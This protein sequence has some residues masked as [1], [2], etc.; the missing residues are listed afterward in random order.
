MHRRRP[1]PPTVTTGAVSTPPPP[2][3]PPLPAAAR[4]LFAVLRSAP[5]EQLR[6]DFAGADDR[7]WRSLTELALRTHTATQVHQRLR[8]AGVVPPPPVRERLA[9]VYAWNATR[10]A[11]L[12]AERDHAC[13]VVAGAG[14][15]VMVLKS[16]HLAPLLYD[17]VG[18]RSMSDVDLLVARADA[19]R[20]Q[21]ALLADGYGPRERPPIEET[22]R[23]HRHLPV[24]RRP[25]RL[26]V[27]LHWTLSEGRGV[28]SGPEHQGVWERAVPIAGLPA[29]GMEP[30]DALL[31]TCRHLAVHHGFGTTNGLSGL[32]DA[33]R[34]LE[35]A[36]ELGLD[37]AAI[38]A[39]A[40]EWRIENGVW[41]CLRLAR[42]LLG[43]PVDERI[44]AALQPAGAD[45][46]LL[47]TAVA[48][49]LQPN[50]LR[51][52]VLTTSP[53]L[54]PPPS[55][56]GILGAAR[57]RGL[58]GYL[59]ATAF[60]PR[61]DLRLDR[62]DLPGPLAW[63]AHWARVLWAHAGVLQWPL[64]REAI[65]AERARRRRL[66]AFVAARPA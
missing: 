35:R 15:R 52:L 53:T 22:V 44:L 50:P 21:D 62:S 23:R 12:L 28:T 63:P 31:F 16:C 32:T 17:G 37:V 10:N 19:Q 20:A 27:E 54:V 6:A 8:S 66:R 14:L 40:R 2:P 25:G 26:P 61:E 57:W 29:L 1:E 42:D 60:P 7:R 43:A 30:L 5:G 38:P 58:A 59:R 36:A 46:E 45:P 48:S 11:Q 3:E 4:D 9:R 34:L 39:R 47:A 55:A 64:R 18:T 33:T 51:G 41:T 65:E 56:S 24:F 49:L 13:A